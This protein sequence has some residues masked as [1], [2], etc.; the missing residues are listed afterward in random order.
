M[1]KNNDELNWKTKKIKKMI[2]KKQKKY[3]NK[4]IGPN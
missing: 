4:K 2:K 3:S 1:K